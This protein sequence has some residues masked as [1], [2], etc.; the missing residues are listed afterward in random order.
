[1]PNTDVTSSIILNP[2]TTLYQVPGVDFTNDDLTQSVQPSEAVCAQLCT[3]TPGCVT[4]TFAICEI[5]YI[6]TCLLK[7]GTGNVGAS[8]CR[9]SGVAAKPIPF[10]YDVPHMKALC[11]DTTGCASF[12]TADGFLRAFAANTTVNSWL[13]NSTCGSSGTAAVE[14]GS[15]F[16]PGTQYVVCNGVAASGYYTTIAAY[17][18]PPFLIESACDQNAACAGYMTQADQT[19]GWLLAWTPAPTGSGVG[20]VGLL[21]S[22]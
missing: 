2:F 19:A 4:Y 21:V 12:S 22:A 15:C 5:A 17:T 10:A 1:M 11:E 20:A 7:S 13:S 3:A 6:D 9:N 18:L 16:S 14:P 8:A